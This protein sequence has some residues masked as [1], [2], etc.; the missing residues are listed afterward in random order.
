MQLR[1]ATR[2]M[3]ASLLSCGI[4]QQRIATAAGARKGDGCCVP[5]ARSVSCPV[6]SDR[7]CNWH[8]PCL[9]PTRDAASAAAG[10]AT[11]RQDGDGQQLPTNHT[12][13]STTADIVVTDALQLMTTACRCSNSSNVFLLSN[14]DKE[15]KVY[16]TIIVGISRFYS[17]VDHYSVTSNGFPRGC[18]KVMCT[19]S[20]VKQSRVYTHNLCVWFAGKPFVGYTYYQSVGLWFLVNPAQRMWV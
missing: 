20:L 10:R 3:R 18:S 15:I 5:C 11:E 8:R 6:P 4:G 14:A 7:A 16:S 17:Q 9:S 12:T 1:S 2:Q 19:V 13:H